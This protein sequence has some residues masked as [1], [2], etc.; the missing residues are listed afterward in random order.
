MAIKRI[1]Q[2]E[3]PANK[4][5]VE[6]TG[7]EFNEVKAIRKEMSFGNDEQ[8]VA[9]AISATHNVVRKGQAAEKLEA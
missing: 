3:K 4:M 9:L 8:A 7:R 5:S 1:K 2:S 6:I